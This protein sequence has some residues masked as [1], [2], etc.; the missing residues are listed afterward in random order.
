MNYWKDGNVTNDHI[1]DNL[2]NRYS[3]AINQVMIATV[4]VSK[5]WFQHYNDLVDIFY[6]NFDSLQIKSCVWYSLLIC[7]AKSI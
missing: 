3:K 1:R 4:K 5:W 6:L 2:W 7:L